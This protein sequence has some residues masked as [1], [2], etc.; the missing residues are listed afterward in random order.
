MHLVRQALADI[1]IIART[2]TKTIVNDVVAYF[3]RQGD[4]STIRESVKLRYG[5]KVVAIKDPSS[6]GTGFEYIESPK[7]SAEVDGGMV[8]VISIGFGNKVVNA[9]ST[10][11]TEPGQK[12][13]LAH[14]DNPEID[15]E[16]A[17]K[18]LNE[19]REKGGYTSAVTR[20]DRR[21]VQAGSSVVYVTFDNGYLHYQVFSPGDIDL[22]F[23]EKVEDGDESRPVDTSDIEDAT[24]VLIKLGEIET[25]RYSYLAVFGRSTVYPNGRHVTFEASDSSPRIPQV[26]DG[27]ANDFEMDGAPANP[28]TVYANQNPDENHLPEYPF[29]VIR[30]GI[31]DAPGVLPVVTSLYN[32][33]LEFDASASHILACANDA[34][35][36][37]KVLERDQKSMGHPLPKVWAGKMAL[38]PGQKLVSVAHGASETK[39]ALEVLRELMVSLASGYS[40]PDYMVISEDYSIEASSG[41]ALQ[42]KT[43]PLIKDRERRVETVKPQIAKMFAVEKMLIQLFGAK[44][45]NA[46][47]ALLMQCD[48]TWDAGKI[49]LP[50]NKKEKSERIIALGDKGILD[51][52][53]QIREYYNLA[54]DDDA[55]ELYEKMKG[56]A[57]DYPP[58]GQ[59]EKKRPLGL[60][61]RRENAQSTNNRPD[62]GGTN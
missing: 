8:E 49:S 51:T 33:C 6:K 15:I 44:E 5:H 38:A 55:I 57:A 22:F 43:R 31:T 52:I 41:I 62:V 42:V 50:E 30:G 32:D 23:G 36:G 4:H 61:N 59:Q 3:D 45:D 11:F 12:Y 48:Q 24:A 14:K 56:R 20:A 35:R 27:D 37:T 2:N 53:G 47:I 10:L 7:F 40:V 60:L 17:D 58:L 28:L 16:A 46:A 26:G 25:G 9:L 19:H 18:L 21:S 29:I 1:N 13:T 39:V 34:A 54:S